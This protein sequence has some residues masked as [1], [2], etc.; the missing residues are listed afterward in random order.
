[1]FYPK[2]FIQLVTTCLFMVLAEEFSYISLL[3]ITLAFTV[4]AFAIKEGIWRALLK[5]TA[6]LFWMIFGVCVYA[7]MGSEGILTV[8]SVLFVVIGMLFW[9]MMIHDFLDEKRA[10]P[11]RFDD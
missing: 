4:F 6:G 1:M 3:V 8:L 9:F 2:I 11:F 10:R 5:Y 7:F